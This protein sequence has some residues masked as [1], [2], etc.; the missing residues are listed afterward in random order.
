MFREHAAATKFDSFIQQLKENVFSLLAYGRYIFHVDKEFATIEIRPGLIARGPQ[1]SGPRR[2]QLA[3]QNQSELV[4]TVD[5]GDHQ[6][7]SFLLF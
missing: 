7:G 5:T 3:L 6:H 2:D 4:R 1:F